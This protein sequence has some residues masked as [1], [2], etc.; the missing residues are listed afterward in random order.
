MPQLA[1]KWRAKFPGDYD[2]LDDHTLEK[3]IL[4]KHPDYKDL[5]IPEPEPAPTPA[6]EIAPQQSAQPIVNEPVIDEGPQQDQGPINQPQQL[7]KWGIGPALYGPKTEKFLSEPLAPEIQHEPD[8]WLGGFGK[9]LYDEFVRPLTSPRNLAVAALTG[10]TVTKAA[11]RIPQIT[12]SLASK[13]APLVESAIKQPSS[14]NNPTQTIETSRQIVSP[15]VSKIIDFSGMGKGISEN[16]YSGLLDKVKFGKSVLQFGVKSPLDQQIIE[17]AAKKGLINSIEDVKK[18]AGMKSDEAKQF[19]GGGSNID[20]NLNQ[21]MGDPMLAGS[22]LP[23]ATSS[24]VNSVSANQG[25]T[26]ILNPATANRMN[27]MYEESAPLMNEMQAEGRFAGNRDVGMLPQQAPI[28]E[29]VLPQT[30]ELP[31][32]TEA[33]NQS[34]PSTEA[35]PYATYAYDWPELDGPQFRIEG[36]TSHGSD[37]GIQGLK[38]LGIDVP[39]Y[40]N[41]PIR[42]SGQQLKDKYVVERDAKLADD[43]AYWNKQLEIEKQN[44]EQLSAINSTPNKIGEMLTNNLIR[45]GEPGRMGSIRDYEREGLDKLKE[46]IQKNGIKEPIILR[47][48][49]QNKGFEIEDGH[50]R[51]QAAR[52]LGIENVPVK[53]GERGSQSKEF[54]ESLAETS[55]DIQRLLDDPR[56]RAILEKNAPPPIAEPSAV[57]KLNAA[58]KEAKP[59]EKEQAAIYTKERGERIA[60]SSKI[61]TPGE[62][63]YF[64]ELAAHKGEHTKVEFT[65]LRESLT[66]PDVDALHNQIKHFEFGDRFENLSAR[67]GLTRILNGSVPQKAQIKSLKKVF[68]ENFADQLLAVK[69]VE[70]HK[71]QNTYDL[72]RGLMGVDPPLVTSAAFRQGASLIGTKDWFKS[73][74]PSVKSY[75]SEKTFQKV[76]DDVN[77]L[78][79]F[80][81]PLLPNG[82]LGESFAEKIG[83]RMTNL[84]DLRE[85]P[86]RSEWA[87]KI[88]IYGKY[89]VRTSNRAFT[90]F[91]N[92]LRGGITTNLVDD[93]IALNKL[94]KSG[95]ITG[96]LFTNHVVP[97]PM[98]DLNFGKQIGEFVNTSTKVGKLGVE[99]GNH[100]LNLE[101]HTRALANAFFSPRGIASQVRML[102][103]STYVMADPFIRKQYVKAIIRQVG[104]WWTLA[105]SAKTG[106]QFVGAHVQ[107]NHD[108]TSSDFGKIK[109]GNMRIDPPGG[110]Q[111]YLVLGAK[112]AAGGSTSTNTGKFNKF[113]EGFK[114]ATMGSTVEDFASNRLHPTAKFAW[115]LVHASK[116]EPFHVTDRILQLAL[117][118][119]MN[120][121]MQVAN[122]EPDLGKRI[123]EKTGAAYASGVG[124]GVQSY[125]KDSFGKPTFWPEKYDVNYKGQGL[126]WVRK[127]FGKEN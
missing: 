9:G 61:T 70:S 116:S 92:V 98:Q 26:D 36:G 71:L 125:D 34:L 12:E 75:G 53:I 119:F 101:K 105:E 95:G 103:P 74:I 69:P 87:E 102:N 52:E 31:Q 24:F 93:A 21:G 10:K 39:D 85:E 40:P 1:E 42:M 72:S 13:E 29:Q 17:V 77:E 122:E 83:V 73:W 88:P 110:L 5:V 113:G 97:N 48:V 20:P 14:N 81:K 28:S 25:A 4:A 114:P 38:D 89:G 23:P 49:D 117:P 94:G 65:P 126:G 90:A 109:I 79:Y 112:L 32:A 59:L 54:V 62:Q 100:E 76:M 58:L 51:L 7:D 46:S 44:K 86:I 3:L 57:E 107:V 91:T 56:T 118:M 64:E 37:K 108:P 78:P 127:M 41:K 60:A 80:K 82:E 18:F 35:K 16:Y 106:A 15:A 2:D 30:T 11:S 50:H 120:D 115:D 124:M 67:D 111:Q 43:N 8:T 6:P 104:V 99:V 96:N 123:L 47:K 45:L 66:Q 68:G 33:F 19:F 63:G 22:Q 27:Q 55:P 121:L 84:R